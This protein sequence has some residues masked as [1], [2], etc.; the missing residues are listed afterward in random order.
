MVNIDQPERRDMRPIFIDSSA[1]IAL[2]KTNDVHHER[3]LYIFRHQITEDIP[4]ITSNTV[5][6]EVLTVLSMRAGKN[7]SVAF[8][9]WFYN[10]AVLRELV[11][12]I[13]VD[14]AIESKAWA[15]FRG[16]KNKNVSFVDC[17]SV[18]ISSINDAQDM[19]TFDKHFNLFEKEYGVKVLN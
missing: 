19:V 17:T 7:I 16:I 9:N 15:L 6:Y 12:N 10:K 14:E 1:W 8:G 2:F 13:F 11:K 5:L 18:I 3:A 4:L